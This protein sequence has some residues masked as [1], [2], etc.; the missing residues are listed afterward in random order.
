MQG[1]WHGVC[2]VVPM[3]GGERSR[4]HGNEDVYGI[5]R[6]Y[7]A[8]VPDSGSGSGQFR[9]DVLRRG[10]FMFAAGGHGPVRVADDS[11]EVRRKMR[12]KGLPV[13]N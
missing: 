13:R 6:I 3:S 12:I 4:N 11:S 5:S 7:A 2:E 9:G 8:Q 10:G 1:E